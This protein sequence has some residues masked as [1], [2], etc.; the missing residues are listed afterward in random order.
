MITLSPLDL[1]NTHRV[2]HLQRGPGQ[3]VYVAP[4]ADMLGER[5]PNTYFH[6]LSKGK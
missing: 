5:N 2:T 4:I 1:G 6:V 3:D